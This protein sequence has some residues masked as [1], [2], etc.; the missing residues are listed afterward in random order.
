MASG[1][2]KIDVAVASGF[3]LILAGLVTSVSTLQARQLPGFGF[4]FLL[5]FLELATGLWLLRNTDA[6]L[7]SLTLLFAAYF[8]LRGVVTFLIAGSHRRQLSVLWE[9][10]L[11]SGVMSLNLAL[12][13]FSG[14]PGPFTYVMGILLGTSFMFH[15]SALVAIALASPEIAE[16]L[17]KTAQEAPYGTESPHIERDTKLIDDL[18]ISYP[19]AALLRADDDP[20]D[21]RTMKHANGDRLD[22]RRAV[23]SRKKAFRP[24]A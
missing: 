9:W 2:L 10:L 8:A 1:V 6:S 11:I 14:L 16:P 21:F 24:Y 15:G 7:K 3:I 23:R 13:M 18:A 19:P 4:S 12:I 22:A 20:L 17:L 5:A